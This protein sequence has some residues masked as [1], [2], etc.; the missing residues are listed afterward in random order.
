M[1]YGKNPVIFA[2]ILGL[3]A[4]LAIGLSLGLTFYSDSKSPS[5]AP[6]PTPSPRMSA[7]APSH[8]LPP[9]A[10]PAA[11][12]DVVAPDPNFQEELRRAR[13]STR[14]WE[15]DFSRHTVPFSEILSGGPP[16]DGIPPLDDPR[17]TTF[18]DA[19]RYLARLEPVPSSR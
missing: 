19:D 2:T 10:V 17:F 16:R 14:G 6:A 12:D 9:A 15:T 4:A 11:A 8:S 3:V 1:R 18:E 5:V 7:P 13:L